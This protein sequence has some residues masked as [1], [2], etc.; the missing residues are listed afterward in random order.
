MFGYPKQNMPVGLK[1]K[2]AWCTEEKHVQYLKHCIHKQIFH[3]FPVSFVQFTKHALSTEACPST[4]MHVTHTHIHPP[5]HFFT[6]SVRPW[7]W[8]SLPIHPSIH[9]YDCLFHVLPLF[10]SCQI[11]FWSET[12][13]ENHSVIIIVFK[14]HFV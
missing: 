2:H 9:L 14:C 11:S 3:A 1:Q 13:K 8:N 10:L 12:S 7:S 5:Y 4:I 6:L